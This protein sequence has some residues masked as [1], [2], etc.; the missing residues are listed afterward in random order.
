MTDTNTL[1]IGYRRPLGGQKFILGVVLLA[2][3]ALALEEG[4]YKFSDEDVETHLEG[5]TEVRGKKN[6]AGRLTKAMAKHEG[7]IDID[8]T[9]VVASALLGDAPVAKVDGDKPEAAAA[10]GAKPEKSGTADKAKSKKPAA[11]AKDEP[12]TGDD[13]KLDDLGFNKAQRARIGD[14]GKA[15]VFLYE[16]KSSEVSVMASGEVRIF[17]TR[18]ADDHALIVKEKVAKDAAKAAKAKAREAKKAAVVVREPKT[19][20]LYI[21][22]EDWTAPD[23]EGKDKVAKLGQRYLAGDSSDRAEVERV[24]AVWEAAED[25]DG[26]I[27]GFK[28]AIQE[29]TRSNPKNNLFE[30]PIEMP[31]ASQ[32]PGDNW[33]GDHLGPHLRAMNLSFEEYVA[34]YGL[35]PKM[36][37]C[38][39]RAR[40]SLKAAHNAVRR[41]HA[42]RIGQM[43]VAIGGDT[44]ASVFKIE[45]AEGEGEGTKYTCAIVVSNDK[46][47]EGAASVQWTHAEIIA[48]TKPINRWSASAKKAETA[49]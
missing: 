7:A 32:I 44:L 18:L 28:A 8:D 35:D 2:S 6:S 49:S 9:A 11:K 48:K 30:S 23:P 25:A 22:H 29:D 31:I 34:E 16:L 10:D 39:N 33:V 4:V 13:K 36:A 45:S 20:K 24:G 17:R 46:A 19:F 5:P 37:K 42:M 1:T 43:C 26:T 15:Q 41:T 38:T 27:F 21:T 14:E 12:L 47:H 40:A 3:E